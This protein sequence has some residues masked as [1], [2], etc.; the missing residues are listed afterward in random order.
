MCLVVQSVTGS[1]C[2]PCSIQIHIVALGK[3]A[4]TFAQLQPTKDW[5]QLS[6][7]L[8][9]IINFPRSALIYHSTRSCPFLQPQLKRAACEEL[10]RLT[11]RSSRVFEAVLICFAWTKA[12]PVNVIYKVVKQ[13]IEHAN[14][15]NYGI[16]WMFQIS[17][18]LNRTEELGQVY[19]EGDGRTAGL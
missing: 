15:S 13:L 10:F 14:Q 16:S 19:I 3:Y 1:S 17:N 6:I 7:Q 2:G 5:T 18:T 12:L 4:N 8:T 11:I 9:T